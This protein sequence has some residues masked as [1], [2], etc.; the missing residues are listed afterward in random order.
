MKKNTIITLLSCLLFS[1]AYAEEWTL[2][3]VPSETL[4]QNVETVYLGLDDGVDSTTHFLYAKSNTSVAGDVSLAESEYKDKSEHTC[5]TNAEVYNFINT[6]SNKFLAPNKASNSSAY[7]GTSKSSYNSLQLIPVPESSTPQKA[8]FFIR[9]KSALDDGNIYYLSYQGAVKW[10][11]ETSMPI[12]QIAEHKAVAKYSAAGL[13]TFYVRPNTSANLLLTFNCGGEGTIDGSPSYT[14]HCTGV[15]WP[16]VQ[17]QPNRVFTGWYDNSELTGD[18]YVTS[19]N[20]QGYY[21][22][23]HDQILYGRFISPTDIDIV[24]WTDSTVQFIYQGDANLNIGARISLTPASEHDWTHA[25]LVDGD[26]FA[27]TDLRIDNHVYELPLPDTLSVYQGKTIFITFYDQSH[28][29]ISYAEQ[30]IPCLIHGAQTSDYIR[31][32]EVVILKGGVLTIT[33][34][35]SLTSVMVCGGGKLVVPQGMQLTLSESLTLRGG[36]YIQ[37]KYGFVYPQ[38]V[39]NGSLLTPANRLTY[40]YLVSSRQYYSLTLPY[41]V[42]TSQI[43]Y[44]DGSSAVFGLQYYDGQKRT[45]RN[46]DTNQSQSGWV[47]A[48]KPYTLQPGVGYTIYGEP[49][50][51]RSYTFLQ[52]PMTVDLSDGEKTGTA[53]TYKDVPV[54]PWGDATVLPNDRG[55]NLVGNPYLANYGAIDGL[56]NNGIG[57]LA[58]ES[59]G[60]VWRGDL[61]YVIVPNDNGT[62]FLP[63][64]AERANLSAF[65]NF[66]V[67]IGEGDALRFSLNQRV[68][69]T[70]KR[71]VPTH[72]MATGVSLS[73]ASRTDYAGVIISKEYTDAYE[74]NADLSKWQN[75]DLNIYVVSQG[76]QLCFAAMNAESA[77]HISL[78][79]SVHQSG[80]Y[81]IRFDGAHYNRSALAALYL[82]DAQLNQEVNLFEQDYTFTAAAN[83]TSNRRFTL[84]CASVKRVP[85]EEED[86]TYFDYLD[87]DNALCQ[88]GLTV[89]DSTEYTGRVDFGWGGEDG[90]K[91]RHTI[92]DSA[93]FDP[94]TGGNLLMTLPDGRPSVRLGNT[95]W[96]DDIEAHKPYRGSECITYTI[97]ITQQHPFLV[98]YYAA[99]LQ[100]PAHQD[101]RPKFIMQIFDEHGKPLGSECYSFDFTA[102]DQ[103]LTNWHTG[104]YYKG[105]YP[106]TKSKQADATVCWKEWTTMGVDLSDYIGKT[107]LVRLTTK[108]CGEYGHYGYA[109]FGLDRTKGK[110]SLV[111]CGNTSGISKFKAPQGFLYEWTNLST[112]QVIS[113]ADSIEVLN[114]GTIYSCK[115]KNVE[116]ADCYFTVER[117]AESRF[118]IARFDTVHY[119]HPG[120]CQDTVILVNTSYISLNA[121]GT[122]TLQPLTPCENAEWHIVGPDTDFYLYQYQ[123]DSLYL[124]TGGEYLITLKVGIDD[125]ACEST[126]DQKAIVNVISTIRTIEGDDTI[127]AGDYLQHGT[128]RHYDAGFFCDTVPDNIRGCHDTI[129]YKGY[130]HVNPVYRPDT[131][132]V[133]ICRGDFYV[134][135]GLPYTDP[136]YYADTLVSVFGCDSIL[137]LHL[138]V[139]D[140]GETYDSPERMPRRAAPGS[141]QDPF[142]L[143]IRYDTVCNDSVYIWHTPSGEHRYREGGIYRDTLPNQYGCD[144]IIFLYLYWKGYRQTDTIQVCE[145]DTFVWHGDTL[146]AD[147]IY[148]DTTYNTEGCFDTLY[149]LNFSIYHPSSFTTRDTICEDSLRT[150]S[151]RG[152]SYTDQIEAHPV[153]IADTDRV[154][155]DP[156]YA[157]HSCLDSLCTLE[158]TIIPVTT[159]DRNRDTICLDSVYETYPGRQYIFHQTGDAVLYDTIRYAGGCDSLRIQQ[160]LHIKDCCPVLTGSVTATIPCADDSLIT[161]TFSD[162]EAPITQY[163]IRFEPV[164]HSRGFSDITGPVDTVALQELQIV[165]P[166]S[167]SVPYLRPDNYPYTVTLEGV[168]HNTVEM[169]DT[170]RVLY[171]AWIIEQRWSDVLALLNKDF[172][173]GYEFS[174]VRWFHDGL[175]MAAQGEHQSY[176][177]QRSL[178]YG[179]PYWAELTRTDDGKTFRTCAVYPVEMSDSTYVGQWDEPVIQIVPD[180]GKIKIESNIFGRYQIYYV[181]GQYVGEGTI[182]NSSALPATTID[183]LPSQG[184]YILVC[185][186]A[187]GSVKTFKLLSE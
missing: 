25:E 108:D 126:V 88:Y 140:Y 110:I 42:E 64:L 46:P 49:Q 148:K 180:Q 97:P 69:Q 14:T 122:D 172:N 85:V 120:S 21:M 63:M 177:L 116:N 16:Q 90:W 186:L 78:G 128:I 181:D 72:Q 19:H 114:D 22:A 179:E 3:P 65:K 171:P 91:S 99:V 168:C 102:G 123:P 182:V 141:W 93:V 125:W 61:R 167:D 58:L 17:P 132:S 95:A 156:H 158:L 162:I 50:D 62:Y 87:L 163:T 73:S 18:E 4:L 104:L 160:P 54:T 75:A 38:L 133:T 89:E 57:L 77:S 187:D 135:N 131:T 5:A 154:F 166:H 32:D 74:Y 23:D 30:T 169:T 146:R 53:A 174:A 106:G 48:T 47:T 157:D 71:A 164:A 70:P 124:V 127:C 159:S 134:F 178:S 56:T 51:S 67:Q 176:M 34:N 27:L 6:Y 155:I 113:T 86:T 173:G 152:R 139:Y 137:V 94:Y 109:Y 151:W 111:E 98:L 55:W 60:Y 107:V 52:F 142:S 35:Q 33:A 7:A 28:R 115:M 2:L 170:I 10:Y 92:C 161:L 118:P 103:G 36:E 24:T 100:L 183:Y 26:T 96:S 143:A 43:T 68:Q 112:G 138:M 82:Y 1:I 76:N 20:C 185:H 40:E 8:R 12:N 9:T 29:P 105:L 136:G 184:L 41:A 13:W 144:S 119:H 175:P 129:I 149:T 66:F 79:Y 31:T 84:R 153:F 165:L 59:T 150:Y 117:K 81:T 145:I 15:L 80:E 121:E 83:E 11:P 101:K 130:L 39:V 44:R 147:G 45:Q 37:G